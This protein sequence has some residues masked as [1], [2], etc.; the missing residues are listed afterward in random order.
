[1]IGRPSEYTQEIADKICEELSMGNS[2][3]TVCAASDM[4]AIRSVFYWMRTNKSFLQQYTRAKEESSDALAEE[5]QDIADEVLE[6]K[7]AINKARLRIDTR[8][9]IMAKMKPKKYGDKVDL[10]TNGKDL[11]TPLLTGVI[12]VRGDN[13][14]QEAE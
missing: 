10:T 7:E 9:F 1:M 2:L 6:D 12:N 8:K 13:G 4:P 5:I 14:S 11:P 3:R